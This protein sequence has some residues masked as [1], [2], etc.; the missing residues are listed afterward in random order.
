MEQR[1]VFEIGAAVR[2]R[3]LLSKQGSCAAL[4]WM[5]QPCKCMPELLL[6]AACIAVDHSAAAPPL[7]PAQVGYHNEHHDF[8]QIPQTRL[9][10]VRPGREA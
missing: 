8:P 1:L 3:G 7:S 6:S 5:V 10:K 2:S 9:H 4:Q